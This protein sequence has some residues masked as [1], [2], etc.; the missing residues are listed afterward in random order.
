MKSVNTFLIAAVTLLVSGEAWAVCVPNAGPR[1][2]VTIQ[3]YLCEAQGTNT[4]NG[5]QFKTNNQCKW[6]QGCKALTTRDSARDAAKALGWDPSLLMDNR[7]TVAGCLAK[8]KRSTD[9]IFLGCDC[10]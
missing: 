9:D 5:C 10:R 6:I 3:T 7:A 1:A 4:Q 2:A 8:R